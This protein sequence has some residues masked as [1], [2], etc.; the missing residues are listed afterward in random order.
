MKPLRFDPIKT[1]AREDAWSK[2]LVD[3]KDSEVFVVLRASH[4]L[5]PILRGNRFK[6][7]RTTVPRVNLVT[8]H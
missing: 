1:K 8:D 3:V 7:V 5:G 2:V 6:L 4:D